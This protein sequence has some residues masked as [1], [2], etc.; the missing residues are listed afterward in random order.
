MNQKLL[1][2]VHRTS[3]RIRAS[4]SG[5]Y[6][7]FIAVL[8]LMPRDTFED[9]PVFSNADV[10]AHFLMYGMLAG[11]LCW[12]LAGRASGLPLRYAGVI[13]F[14]AAYGML[15]ELL[16]MAFPGL[17]RMFSWFDETANCAGAVAVAAAWRWLAGR[18]DS[19][20]DST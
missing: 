19:P 2:L 9:I 11:M 3:F 13:M 18:R 5:A 8:S 16:Q 4:L 14:C 15:I 1:N 7:V 6:V 17:G 12:M 20:P 10:V